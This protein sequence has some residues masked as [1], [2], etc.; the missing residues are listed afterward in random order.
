M[1]KAESLKQAL[2]HLVDYCF[3][4]AEMVK[5]YLLI[6][7]A[8]APIEYDEDVVKFKKRIKKVLDNISNFQNEGRHEGG[9]VD[10]PD[11]YKKAA[12]IK[13]MEKLNRGQDI[14]KIVDV[15]CFSGWLGR[16]L[17]Y[18]GYKV[19]GIDLDSKTL[20]IA[21]LMAS[22]TLATYE[23][24]PAEQLG[25]THPR[26]YDAAVLFDVLEHLFDYKLA[27]TSV[28]NSVREDGWVFINLPHEDQEQET[29]GVPDEMKQHLHAFNQQKVEEVFGG[30]KNVEIE[31]ID[32]EEGNYNWFISYQVGD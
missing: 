28:E 30:K 4:H 6:E 1:N 18:Q 22:G 5:A 20:D 15:G 11:V 13:L 23:K 17:T 26:E 19:H 3:D 32:N 12:F 7:N 14:K 10:P 9:F 31:V 24:L 21:R 29:S 25:V 8:P 27:L 16:T 2:L